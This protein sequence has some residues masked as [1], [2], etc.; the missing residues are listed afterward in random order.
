MLTIKLLF[1]NSPLHYVIII[2][3]NFRF[4]LSESFILAEDFATFPRHKSIKN[5]Y[6]FFFLKRMKLTRIQ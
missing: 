1:R 6:F 3:E 4:I 2:I 5:Y